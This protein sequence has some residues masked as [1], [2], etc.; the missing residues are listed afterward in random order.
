MQ[1][2]ALLALDTTCVNRRL[3][4]I[5]HACQQMMAK[6]GHL[7]PQFRSLGVTVRKR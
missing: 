7:L 2:A 3:V 1:A 6:R 5:P 4:I